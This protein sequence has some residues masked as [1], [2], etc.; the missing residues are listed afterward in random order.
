MRAKRP[1]TRR[2]SSTRCP[3][4]GQAPERLRPKQ[5][6]SESAQKSSAQK[7]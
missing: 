7:D 3:L 6:K 1:W 5:V 2:P 4:G